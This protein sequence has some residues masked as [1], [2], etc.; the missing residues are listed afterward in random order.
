MI[1]ANAVPVGKLASKVTNENYRTYQIDS[2]GTQSHLNGSVTLVLLVR[3]QPAIG[4]IP[5][6]EFP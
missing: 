1:G 4:G 3:I 2:T 5:Q 6:I